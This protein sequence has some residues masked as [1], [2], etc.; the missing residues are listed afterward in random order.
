MLLC[1]TS[2]TFQVHLEQL[3]SWS[4]WKENDYLFQCSDVSK[5]FYSGDFCCCSVWLLVIFV[6]CWNTEIS[7]SY[8]ACIA[9]LAFRCTVAAIYWLHPMQITWISM[10]V[11]VCVS[12]CVSVY[13][14]LAHSWAPGSASQWWPSVC[15]W[16]FS[17]SWPS[18]R[19]LCGPKANTA[20]T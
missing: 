8:S 7:N 9:C 16:L 4:V 14:R 17:P 6:P 11:R 5:I 13:K 19:W 10:C 20:A 1:S 3:F 15:L 18:S 2:P 12:L